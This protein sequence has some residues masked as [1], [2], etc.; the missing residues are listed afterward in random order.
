MNLHPGTKSRN[1]GQMH[2]ISRQLEFPAVFL[3]QIV[4]EVS[5]F[6]NG[7]QPNW[8]TWNIF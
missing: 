4:H 2:K 5:D 8:S 6:K 7:S 3:I 1:Q